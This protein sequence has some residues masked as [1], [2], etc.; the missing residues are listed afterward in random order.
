MCHKILERIPSMT[1]EERLQLRGNCERAKAR[2]ADGLV[3]AEAVRILDALDALQRRELSVLG[4]LAGA[5]RIEYAF[6]RLPANERERLAIRLLHEHAGT[7]V[8]RLDAAWAEQV[9]DAWHRQIGAMCRDR[10]HLLR[11]DADASPFDR[12]AA[13]VDWSAW[14]IELDSETQAVRLKPDAIAAFASL[15]YVAANA[16]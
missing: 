7:P 3:R 10:R 13:E 12:A 6:R 15:G 16:A 1:A 11:G 9:G 2:T 14:L 4:R 8:G 5:R